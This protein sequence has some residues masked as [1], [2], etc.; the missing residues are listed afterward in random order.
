ME[1]DVQPVWKLYLAHYDQEKA[2][3][4]VGALMHG[5]DDTSLVF[6]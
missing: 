4:I 1:R 5:L 2:C 3:Q 6:I